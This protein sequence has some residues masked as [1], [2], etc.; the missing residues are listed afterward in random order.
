MLDDMLLAPKARSSSGA[1]S[2][3]GRAMK[4]RSQV[5][6]QRSEMI[7]VD[8]VDISWVSRLILTQTV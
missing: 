6:V 5:L 3:T 7:D 4:S 2:E 8:G 1:V